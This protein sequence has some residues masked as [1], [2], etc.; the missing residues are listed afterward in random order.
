[1]FFGLTAD[2]F[3]VFVRRLLIWSNYTA[4]SPVTSATA[5]T[6]SVLRRKTSDGSCPPRSR[7]AERP[8]TSPEVFTFPGRT[9]NARQ[10]PN[11]FALS[12]KPTG[13]IDDVETLGIGMDEVAALPDVA[14]PDDASRPEHFDRQRQLCF[15]PGGSPEG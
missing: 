2:L 12:N 3:P 11:R 9:S 15:E 7:W 5:T 1:G 6:R 13:R 4:L 8:S 14:R 10:A